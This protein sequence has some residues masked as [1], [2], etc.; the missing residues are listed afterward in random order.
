MKHLTCPG[1]NQEVLFSK[2]NLWHFKDMEQSSSFTKKELFFLSPLF[3][4]VLVLT[5]V[6]VIPNWHL[7]VKSFFHTEN[8]K[9][10][11]VLEGALTGPGTKYKIFKIKTAS[12]IRIEIYQ[13]QEGRTGQMLTSIDLP[14]SRDGYFQLKG[15]LTNFA[16]IDVNKDDLPEILLSTYDDNLVPRLYALHFDQATKR[17]EILDKN[18]IDLKNL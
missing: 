13:L 11:S 17:I 4:L 8:R 10:L 6:A 16:L 7:P 5:A 9:I 18:K 1:S 15:N 14:E 12:S 2:H 3:S